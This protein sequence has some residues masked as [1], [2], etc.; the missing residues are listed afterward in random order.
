MSTLTGGVWRYMS[1]L[2][3]GVWRYMSTLTGGVW[4]YMSTLT[5]GALRMLADCDTHTNMLLFL[6]QSQGRDGALHEPLLL[7]CCSVW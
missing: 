5:G 7:V 6:P 2:T 3:G 1:T 4:R